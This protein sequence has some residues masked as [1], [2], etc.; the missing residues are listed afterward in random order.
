MGAF[1]EEV[2]FSLCPKN[3]VNF[4]RQKSGILKGL[5]KVKEAG[6]HRSSCGVGDSA[7][8][9]V[10]VEREREARL[11]CSQEM[12]EVTWTMSEP[13]MLN[14]YMRKNYQNCYVVRVY[15]TQT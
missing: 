7:F 12:C 13:Q 8:P 6:K 1:I 3:T 11:R 9:K 4:A 14:I 2:S 5:S 10:T 15:N